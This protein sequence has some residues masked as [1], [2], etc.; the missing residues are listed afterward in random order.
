MSI[1]LRRF[2]SITMPVVT[3]TRWI[4]DEMRFTDLPRCT[5]NQSSQQSTIDDIVECDA[6]V[7]L[8]INVRKSE[9]IT[10][11]TGSAQTVRING[12]QVEQVPQFCYL[13]SVI[14]HI[15]TSERWTLSSDFTS[16]SSSLWFRMEIRQTY[17][18]T[19]HLTGLLY[20]CAIR[21]IL[22]MTDVHEAGSS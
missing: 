6:I 2:G 8:V 3:L 17:W 10:A 4:I 19:M 5:V 13:V 11:Y 12:D 14:L 16:F 18:Y 21:H 15:R 20:T 9:V 22:H 7:N 1:H